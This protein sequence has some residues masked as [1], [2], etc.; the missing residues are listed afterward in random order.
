MIGDT[1]A[2]LDN[3]VPLPRIEVDEPA[4]SMT[5]GTNTSPL[6]G[7]DPHPGVK[8]T[9]RQVRNRLDS[10]LVGNVSIR[11]LPTERPDT[12][13]VQGRGEL[14]LA[15]LVEQ[16]RREGFELTVGKP[17]VVTRIVDG[18]LHEPYERLS[19]DVPTEYLGPITQL[20]AARKG[21]LL[22]MT[23]GEVR[24]R[25]DYTVPSRG[26]IGFR[27]DFL[28]VTRGSGIANHVFDGYRPWVGELRTRHSGSLVSDRSGPV[29]AYACTQLADR[30]TMFVS[31][32]TQVYNG[33]VVG[34]SSRGDDLDIN[35][36]REKKLTNVRSSTSDVLET[37]T[38]ATVL[39]LEQALEFCASDECVEVTPESVRV[40][41]TELDS[42]LRAR[43]RSR[44]KAPR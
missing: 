33:M 29:T 39:N 17:E 25:L 34:E 41:K 10:E 42:H 2:D 37:L 40:R 13:E 15:V 28:T 38:P 12:W 26:L 19:I 24:V 11:V 9:A 6:A 31:P 30:G 43:A 44:A 35:I 22:Q 27:T 23:H 20:L 18:K 36:T 8:L 3:P 7:R 1:L 5:I 14:A 32:G 16:M 4:I 21:E